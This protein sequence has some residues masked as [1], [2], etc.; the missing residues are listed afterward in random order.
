M[1]GEDVEVEECC[2]L[3]KDIVE[4]L[5]KIIHIQNGLG[6]MKRCRFPAILRWHSFN[7]QKEPEKYH[8]AHLMLF[9]PW[10]DE[11]NLKSTY[12][13]CSER[14]NAEHEYKSYLHGQP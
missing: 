2:D 10:R 8:R 14:Y 13:S 7:L 6:T 3:A 9:V 5:P 11:S 1:T 4:D 12:N